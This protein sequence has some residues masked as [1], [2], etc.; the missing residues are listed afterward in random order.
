MISVDP[1]ECL[2]FKPLISSKE[3]AAS[4][5]VNLV[6]TEAPNDSCRVLL[7]SGADHSFFAFVFCLVLPTAFPTKYLSNKTILL[8]LIWATHL[9]Q[10]QM[11]YYEVMVFSSLSIFGYFGHIMYCNLPSLIYPVVFSVVD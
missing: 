3:T 2:S 10:N 1:H 6:S 4:V 9:E 5:G 7:C 11:E 8:I